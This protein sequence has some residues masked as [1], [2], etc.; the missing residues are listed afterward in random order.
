MNSNTAPSVSRS[1][2]EV[3]APHGGCSTFRNPSRT[4]AVRFG[5]FYGT[6]VSPFL[7]RPQQTIRSPSSL[8]VITQ[9]WS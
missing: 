6:F 9:E 2:N 1:L 5:S 8:S 4:R 3:V 7:L